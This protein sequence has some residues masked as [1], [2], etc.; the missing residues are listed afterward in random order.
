MKRLGEKKEN[1][2]LSI[3]LRFWMI[4]CNFDVRNSHINLSTDHV[5]LTRTQ[6]V[7]QKHKHGQG[8]V[9][10][11]NVVGLCVVACFKIDRT[12]QNFWN[13]WYVI[14]KLYF[15]K[16]IKFLNCVFCILFSLKKIIYF[17]IFSDIFLF[18][19]ILYSRIIFERLK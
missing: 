5:Y 16:N 19:Q 9:K 18:L 14:K 1:I 13:I 12:D 3:L 7:I 17:F 11:V 15:H 4:F 8:H 2:M 10:N 6:R